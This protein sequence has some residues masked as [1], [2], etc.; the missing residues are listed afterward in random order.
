MIHGSSDLTDV[1]KAI[2]TSEDGEWFIIP[3]EHVDSW[4]AQDRESVIVH[5]CHLWNKDLRSENKLPWEVFG[6]W[7]TAGCTSVPCKLCEVRP[8]EAIASLWLLHN[9]DTF[10]NDSFIE[11]I[12]SRAVSR[13]WSGG[14]HQ[15]YIRGLHESS[16][17]EPCPCR[18][19]KERYGDFV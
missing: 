11:R 18:E 9:F 6:Y 7:T 5:K 3:S 2:M 19:C 1:T 17:A 10:S 13:A 4:V 12:V 8:P 14:F 16:D 15:S